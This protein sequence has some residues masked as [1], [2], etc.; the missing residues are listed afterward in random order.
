MVHGVD[1][2][3][4]FALDAVEDEHERG[5]RARSNHV[6]RALI[7]VESSQ[8]KEEIK[9]DTAALMFCSPTCFYRCPETFRNSLRL[10][11]SDAR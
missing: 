10:H 8:S 7:P 5:L 6:A 11:V 2:E 3:A 4:N 1:L 9:K